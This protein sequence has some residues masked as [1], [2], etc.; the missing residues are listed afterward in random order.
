MLECSCLKRAVYEEFS[1]FLLIQCLLEFEFGPAGFSVCGA[2]I[3]SKQRKAAG[4]FGEPFARKSQVSYE[5]QA[6]SPRR[7]PAAMKNSWPLRIR[8][9]PSIPHHW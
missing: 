1:G 7:L 5:R 8:N 9:R 2:V 3:L 4:T 6:D